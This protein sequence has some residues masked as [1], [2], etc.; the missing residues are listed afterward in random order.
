M[1]DIKMV[2]IIKNIDKCGRMSIGKDYC[3]TM[4]IK[5]GDFV[6][7]SLYKTKDGEYLLVIKKA[8]FRK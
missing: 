8:V 3:E 6:E 7:Q 5:Y 4:G 1:E 2:G